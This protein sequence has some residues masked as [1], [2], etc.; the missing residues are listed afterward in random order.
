M[1]GKK[2]RNQRKFPSIHT[3]SRG[4]GLVNAREMLQILPERAWKVRKVL[5]KSMVQSPE[6]SDPIWLSGQASRKGGGT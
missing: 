6:K 3:G 4:R 2:V 5:Q 1:D